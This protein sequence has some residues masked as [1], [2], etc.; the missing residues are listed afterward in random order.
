M[1]KLGEKRNF[2][3][4]ALV[5][6]TV[7]CIFAYLAV[8]AFVNFRGFTRYC[9][10]DVYADMQVAKR[11]WEQKTLF[12]DGW[13]F[14][15]QS[16]VVATPALAALLYGLTGSINTAMIL[17]TEVMTV[18]ILLSLL[19]LLRS[20]TENVLAQCV[21]CLLMLSSVVVPYGPYSM[22][23]M[24]FYTQAS[25][26]ACYLIVLLVT[27]G[28]YARA[29]K[30][31]KTRPAAWALVLVLSF[32]TGMQSLRQTIVTVLPI[33]TFEVLRAFRRVLQH[34]KPWPRENVDSLL[35]GCSYAAANLAGI[36]AVKFMDVPMSPIYGET[37][38]VPPGQ[39]GQRLGAIPGA[40]YEI[41]QLEYILAGDCS[42]LIAIVILFMI[43]LVAAA[44]VLLLLRKELRGTGLAACW[45]LC[46]IGILGVFLSSVVLQ[47][48]LRGIY[49]FMWFPLVVFSGLLLLRQFPGICGKGLSAA[50]CLLSLASLLYC[51][52]PY[53][54]DI[55]KGEPT[56]KAQMSQWAAENGY[57]YVYGEYWGTAPQIAACSDGAL[58]AGCWHTPE[59]VFQA[60]PANTPQ[61]IYGVEENAAALYV[62]TPEDE[63]NG[64]R[65]A[66]ERGAV[67]T[68]VAQFGDYCAYTAS[69]PLMRIYES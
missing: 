29:L 65:V 69:V 6:V 67:L 2:A 51:F 36:I 63:E 34:R 60:E 54:S 11:M 27:F 64:L 21:G 5:F 61:N 31:E 42:K 43:A 26:Y 7:V 8:F 44:A 16:Y 24:L 23:S 4:K 40:V 55:T 25:F 19:W 48:T 56:N 47:I 17:A 12:P 53:L 28:D 66:Q 58:E 57:R 9:N 49:A 52:A 20:F 46:L 68:K 41:T 45:L 15:N 33:L 39:W 35:R 18:L 32:A 30:S 10:S 37:Q 59:N 13:I 50:I 14:C 1:M 3:E 22:N 38:L 62:F